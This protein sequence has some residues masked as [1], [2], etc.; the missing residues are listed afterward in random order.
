M[1]DTKT[2]TATFFGRSTGLYDKYV[3]QAKSWISQQLNQ[4]IR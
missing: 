2:N 1:I 4:S 3:P